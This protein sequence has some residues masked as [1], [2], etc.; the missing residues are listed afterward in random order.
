MKLEKFTDVSLKILTCVL[1]AVAF[2][3]TFTVSDYY[4]FNRIGF[5]EGEF[6]FFFVLSQWVKKSGLLLIPLAV[7]LNKKSCADIAK[8]VLPMFVI[9]SCFVPDGFFTATSVTADSSPAE[10]VY[11]HINEFLPKAANITFFYFSN[12]LYL[13]ICALLFVKH[14]Y[15][16]SAKSFVY[17][18]F[19]FLACTPLNIFE[20]FFDISKIP[21]GSFLRFSNFSLWHFLA[22]LCL[23]GVTV[24]AYYFLK[25]KDRRLQDDFLLAA[26]IVLLIQYHSKDSVIMGDGYNVYHTVFACVPLF[27]CNLGVYVVCITIILKKRVLYS[28]SFFVHAAGALSV[29]F[30]FGKEEMS[31]YGIF[32]SYSILYFTFT[33]CILFALAVLPTAL[34]HYKFRFKDAIIPL[35]YYL[36]V[37]I[38]AAVASALVTS[39]SMS[40]SYNGYTLQEGEWLLPNYAFTQE[41][42]FPF[43][44]PFI[45]I[46]IWKYDLSLL[47]VLGLYAFY[48]GIFATMNALYFLFLAVR[49]AV[50][51]RF[52]KKPE[53]DGENLAQSEAAVSQAFESEENDG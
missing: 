36:A 15:K 34:G 13:A 46:R 23:G 22:V 39:A 31:N 28:I 18:P 43:T 38:I 24:G 20:N 4:I 14:G 29:F 52:D 1:C 45:K 10:L 33:H 40:F 53:A 44:V 32:C 9:I 47:Y 49:K 19:A 7:Y 25:N 6:N 27:I 37:V 17:L 3:L 2:L 12:F 30:Y 21:Q 16:V 5:D 8:Y 41:N 48:V 26:A 35:V 50:L 11:A 42:P 51:K